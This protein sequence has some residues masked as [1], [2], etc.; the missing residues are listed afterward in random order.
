MRHYLTA[1]GT[2]VLLALSAG[3]ALA[4]VEIDGRIDPAEWQGARHVTDFKLVEPL[5]RAASPYPTEAWVLATPEGLAIGF[6]NTQPASVQRTYQRTRRDQDAQVDRVNLMVDFDGDGRSGYNF[7][8]TITDGIT[9]ATI[10]NESQF[11]S[12]WDGNWKHAVSEDGDTWS[13]EMLIP[14]YIAPMRKADDGTRT[15]GLYLDRVIGSTGERVAPRAR[16]HPWHVRC[17]QAAECDRQAIRRGQYPGFGRIR[18]GLQR[19]RLGQ[20]EIVEVA[21]ALPFGRVDASVDLDRTAGGGSSGRRRLSRMGG[22]SQDG[23]E[24]QQQL[25]AHGRSG[26]GGIWCAD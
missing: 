18:R 1:I 6:R 9:D 19:Q 3:P 26:Q 4:A 25:G 13:A 17:L 15:V 21:R 2:S 22:G 24:G 20:D 8:V 11:N 7:T 16:A 5:T 10:T 12:D 14:W 23:Q